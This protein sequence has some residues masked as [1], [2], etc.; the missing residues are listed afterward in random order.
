MLEIFA[1][2][3]LTGK[4]GALAGQKGQK[5]GLWKFYTVLAWFGMEIIGAVLSVVIFKTDNLLAALPLAYG[6]AI[7][8]YFLLRSILS[9]MPDVN[10]A[11][12]EFE[13]NN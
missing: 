7:G 13:K 11:A 4:I 10:D 2:I 6:F 5:K 8:G 9:K 3:Y 1:L 12:F